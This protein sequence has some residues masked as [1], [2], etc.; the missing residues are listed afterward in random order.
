VLPIKK[1]NAQVYPSVQTILCYD[2]Y[3]KALFR[4]YREQNILRH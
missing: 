4:E 2:I 1:V 3:K